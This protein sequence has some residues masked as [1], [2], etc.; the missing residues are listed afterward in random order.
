MTARAKPADPPS[1][2]SVTG[3][4]TLAEEERMRERCDLIVDFYQDPFKAEPAILQKLH[5]LGQA[6]SI[7]QREYIEHYIKKNFPQTANT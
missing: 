2:V 4:L 1:G 7:P 6:L 3:K 5:N